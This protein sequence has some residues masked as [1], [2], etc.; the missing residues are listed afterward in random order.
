[1]GLGPIYFALFFYIYIYIC[2]VT[3]TCNTVSFPP[4]LILFLT[5]IKFANSL[6]FAHSYEYHNDIFQIKKEVSEILVETYQAGDKLYGFK[7][8]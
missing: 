7:F 6:S 5:Q 4:Y 8:I 2:K 1:M 3:I